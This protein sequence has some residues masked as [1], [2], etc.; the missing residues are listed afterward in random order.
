M[1]NS[2]WWIPFLSSSTCPPL[3]LLRGFG[4]KGLASTLPAV[5]CPPL[6]LLSLSLPSLSSASPSPLSP[7]PRSP[8]P[9]SLQPRGSHTHP[10]LPTLPQHPTPQSAP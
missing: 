1:R 5:T 7:Q 6:S 4:L 9:L 8:S 10:L 3:S 2:R